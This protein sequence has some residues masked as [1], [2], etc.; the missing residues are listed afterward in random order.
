MAAAPPSTIKALNYGL[1]AFLLVLPALILAYKWA[2][3]T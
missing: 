2:T 1:V 3:G